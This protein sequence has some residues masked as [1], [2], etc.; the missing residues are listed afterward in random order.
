[1]TM[2]ISALIGAGITLL[3]YLF[4]IKGE[5]NALGALIAC[6]K[7]SKRWKWL[8]WQLWRDDFEN[9]FLDRIW[10]RMQKHGRDA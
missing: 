7:H 9:E 3:P 8:A 4:P 6:C 2:I 10:E 5:T 1:M